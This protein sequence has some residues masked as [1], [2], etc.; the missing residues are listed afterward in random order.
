VEA[1]LVVA[2]RMI[3]TETVMVAAWFVCGECLD[4][5]VTSVVDRTCKSSVV[6]RILLEEVLRIVGGLARGGWLL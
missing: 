3:G 5:A 4:E 1:W 6:V 2:A